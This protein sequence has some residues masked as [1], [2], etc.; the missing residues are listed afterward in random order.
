MSSAQTALVMLPA[1]AGN[2][3]LDT[4]ELEFQAALQLLIGRA[5]WVTGAVAGALALEEHGVFAYKAASGEGEH[6]PGTPAATETDPI[7]ECLAERWTVRCAKAHAPGFTMA[8]PL[9]RDDKAIGFIELTSN[10]EFTAEGSEVV[11]R[12]ADLAIV[13]LEHRHAAQRAQEL[14]FR[15]DELDLPSLWHAPD[16]AHKNDAR[17]IGDVEVATIPVTTK[18]SIPEIGKCAACGFPVSPNRSLCVECEQNPE[19]ASA[20]KPLFTAEPEQS[21]LSEHGYT[22]ASILVTAV[23]VAIILWLKH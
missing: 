3:L 2:S 14:N 23:T 17:F 12:I 5:C 9:V 8:V 16:N 10:L 15:E 18:S 13:A 6:D 7:R 21:W 22:I 4:A 19:S 1:E 20:A 11:A